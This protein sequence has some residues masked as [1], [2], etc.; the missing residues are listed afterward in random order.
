MFCKIPPS[1][2]T[3]HGV[4]NVVVMYLD[5]RPSDPESIPVPDVDVNMDIK[6]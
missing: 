3:L 1:I 6:S 5:S 4:R 2:N